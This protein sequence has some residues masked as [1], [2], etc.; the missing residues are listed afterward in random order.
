MKKALIKTHQT[1]FNTTPTTFYFS[2]GRVNLIGEHTDYSGGHVLPMALSIGTY[3]SVSKRAD[4]CIAV[5]SKNF[6]NSGVT[7]I[8]LDNLEYSEEAGYINYIKGVLT[9]FQLHKHTINQGL[10]ITIVGTLPT[11]SGLSSSASLELLVTTLIKEENHLIIPTLDLVHYAKAV[12]NTYMGLSSGIMDQF[13]I[14]FSKENHATFLN[15]KTL[16][17]THVPFTLEQYTL[18]L[19]NTNKPRDLVNSKYNERVNSVNAATAHFKNLKNTNHLCALDLPTY[20]A[21][22]HTLK[23]E[24][25]RMRASHVVSENQR[26]LQAKEALLNNDF[27]H[28]GR[29]MN[30]SHDSLKHSFEVSCDELDYLVDAN[31]NLGALGARMTGAGFGGTMIALY[32]NTDLPTD[33]EVLKKNYQ[34]QFNKHLDVYIAKASNGV[35]KI[36]GVF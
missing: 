33:F 36:E 4:Q 27:A 21:L 22:K 19:M 24:L 16:T 35:N 25:M 2:P 34:K 6:P 9:Q 26:T 12:E 13:A 32:K 30:Q 11:S 8:T 31:R 10:N 28:F 29:L 14:A 15:T 5:Y 20:N 23:D 7:H 1:I 3:A 18:I 17:Y